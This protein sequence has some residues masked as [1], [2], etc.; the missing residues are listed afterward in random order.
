MEEK[1]EEESE[2]IEAGEELKAERVGD[3]GEEGGQEDARKAGMA[4]EFL[5]SGGSCA[6]DSSVPLEVSDDSVVVTA[7]TTIMVTTASDVPAKF[8]AWHL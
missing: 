7:L 1:E 4:V 6:G 2:A 5:D 3:V 8:L